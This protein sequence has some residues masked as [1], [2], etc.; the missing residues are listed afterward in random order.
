MLFVWMSLVNVQLAYASTPLPAMPGLPLYPPLP[1]E[2][3]APRDIG[4]WQSTIVYNGYDV[5]DYYIQFAPN[6]VAPH[7]PPFAPPPHDETNYPRGLPY[8]NPLPTPAPP[9][10]APPPAEDDLLLGRIDINQLQSSCPSGAV[11][12]AEQLPDF[13][14][15]EQG[16][17]PGVVLTDAAYDPDIGQLF[18]GVNENGGITIQYNQVRKFAPV[19]VTQA[20][21][22]DSGG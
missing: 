13:K 15:S 20:R 4:P 2:P 17:M 14:S 9:A 12:S 5:T 8:T 3:P 6:G 10:P 21:P 7:P 19:C 1:P 16:F 11:W 18:L 22:V